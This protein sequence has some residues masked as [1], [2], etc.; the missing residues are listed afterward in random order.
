MKE[1]KIERWGGRRPGAGRKATG[2]VPLESVAIRC[3]PAM[4][5]ELRRMAAAEGK[6]MKR[7]LE[8]MLAARIAAATEKS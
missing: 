1:E 6:T 2:P 3:T 8:E 5:E 4:K 7:L